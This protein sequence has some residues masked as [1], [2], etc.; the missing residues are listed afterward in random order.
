MLGA[1]A[2]QSQS[3]TVFLNASNSQM[4][5]APTSSALTTSSNPAGTRS[6]H[7]P[8]NIGGNIPDKAA[9]TATSYK[10]RGNS[11]S[12][13][14]VG[15]VK[16]T[17]RSFPIHSTAP[18]RYA[19]LTECASDDESLTAA[20]LSPYSS[21]MQ[22][23]SNLPLN[24][25]VSLEMLTQSLQA[26]GRVLSSGRP[27]SGRSRLRTSSASSTLTAHKRS[28]SVQSLASTTSSIDSGIARLKFD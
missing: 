20:V 10:C 17:K 5:T 21:D 13:Q 12:L 27:S 18:T 2:K 11:A 3:S 15:S 23:S 4:L 25:R 14:S 24:S 6:I 7:R 22:Q 16:A 8:E 9:T 1:Y 26:V 19:W 28:L